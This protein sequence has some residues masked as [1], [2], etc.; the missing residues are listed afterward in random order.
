[1]IDKNLPFFLEVVAL[2]IEDINPAL[3]RMLRPQEEDGNGIPDTE[4]T[5][6]RQYHYLKR[7]G[8]LGA[9]L[10]YVTGDEFEGGRLCLAE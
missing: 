9:R 7:N 3:E 8:Q 5:Q 4:K 10:T 6:V 1:M 2:D